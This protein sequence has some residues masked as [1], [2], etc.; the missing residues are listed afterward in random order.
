M[1][2][3]L[4]ICYIGLFLAAVLSLVRLIL[5]PTNLDRI[6]AFDSVAL[7]AAGI[8][9][10]FSIQTSSVYFVEVLLIF[11][12]LG[13]STVLGY[14]DYLSHLKKKNDSDQKEDY[15]LE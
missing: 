6:L 3:V 9:I 7:C 14:L 4:T 12:L 8:V 10:L 15:D 13:F 1:S 5:G 2:Y 11:S